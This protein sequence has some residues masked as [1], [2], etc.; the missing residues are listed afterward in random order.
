MKADVKQLP[1]GELK[2]KL[3]AEICRRIAAK[4]LTYVPMATFLDIFKGHL[5]NGEFACPACEHTLLFGGVDRKEPY[6]CCIACW[7]GV[8]TRGDLQ[9]VAMVGKP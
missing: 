9:K 4:E 8:F 6:M 2:Q 7:K 5:A 1:D 3:V